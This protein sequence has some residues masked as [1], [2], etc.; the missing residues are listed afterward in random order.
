MSLDLSEDEFLGGRL[1]ILQPKSGFRAAIDS[2]LLPASLSAANGMRV[3]DAGAGAGVGALCL[4]ARAPEFEVTAYEADA[5]LVDL[6]RESARRNDLPLDVQCRDLLCAREGKRFDQV[7]TN[8]PYLDP[9][10]AQAP[11]DVGKARAHVESAS[12][13]DWLSACFALLE[14]KGYLTLIHRADRLPE[15]LSLLEARAGDIA[16]FPLWP[17]EGKPAR[18]VLV[19]AR[20]DSRSPSRLLAGLMLHGVGERYTNEAEAILRHGAAIDLDG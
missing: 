16:V 18:R 5:E 15:L 8:P 13:G 7:M 3:L 19:R 17:G 1:K 11:P 4:R 12:L 2:V 6:A 9:A 20:K 10:R 14:P